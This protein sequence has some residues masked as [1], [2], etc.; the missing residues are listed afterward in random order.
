[1]KTQWGSVPEMASGSLSQSKQAALPGKP[2]AVLGRLRMF[3]GETCQQAAHC[4][5][6]ST[7]HFTLGLTGRGRN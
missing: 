4:F 7:C 6:S 1:M 2:W 5:S 3:S